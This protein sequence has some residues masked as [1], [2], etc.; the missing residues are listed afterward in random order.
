MI[1]DCSHREPVFTACLPDGKEPIDTGFY[2]QELMTLG[3]WYYA[4]VPGSNRR[5]YYNRVYINPDKE[6]YDRFGLNGNA[7]YFI[8]LDAAKF[9]KLEIKVQ[10]NGWELPSPELVQE[11]TDNFSKYWE[12]ITDRVKRSWIVL[13]PVG[14]NDK[15][16]MLDSENEALRYL[17]MESQSI[18]GYLLKKCGVQMYGP[19]KEKPIMEIFKVMP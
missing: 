9:G 10:G 7:N 18:T 14:R 2:Y 5:A 3:G 13:Y 16:A 12:Y 8:H 17:R 1:E 11:T 15:G 19:H 4:P 6:D